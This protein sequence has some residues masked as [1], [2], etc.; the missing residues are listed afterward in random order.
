MAWSVPASAEPLELRIPQ[1]SLT[2]YVQELLQRAFEAA[3]GKAIVTP[4]ND[5][6]SHGRMMLLV[7]RQEGLDLFWRGEDADLKKRFLEVEFDLTDGLKGVRVLFVR[8]DDKDLYA[9]VQSLDEFRALGTIGAMGY[10][11]NDVQIWEVNG[12]PVDLTREHWNPAIYNKL[13]AGRPGVDYFSRGI[14]EMAVEAPQHPELAVEP[15]LQLVY[16]NDF[17]LYVSKDR[18][19]LHKLLTDVLKS[20]DAQ[21]IL[22]QTLRDVFPDIFRPDGLNIEGRRIIP[23]AMPVP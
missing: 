14:I 5:P 12:L 13:A 18:P 6:L 23:L 7:E 1:H 17:R 15:H 21:G 19:D 20:A 9:H 16:E 8:P 22:Q 10:D 2:H 11:W 4:A 3:G